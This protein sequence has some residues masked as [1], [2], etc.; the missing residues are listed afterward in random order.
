[1]SELVNRLIV[2]PCSLQIFHTVNDKV[3]F[4]LSYCNHVVTIIRYARLN[5]LLH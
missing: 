2:I 1:M 5:S 3:L 4:I